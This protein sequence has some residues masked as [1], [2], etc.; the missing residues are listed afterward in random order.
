MQR[1]PHRLP[2]EAFSALA[3]GGGGAAAVRHLRA[4]ERSRHL[5]LILGVV[6]TARQAGHPHAGVAAGAYDALAAL[7]RR[8]P[9]AVDRL[10]RH[11]A[12]GAWA[13]HTVSALL[14][15]QD[16][17]H[18]PAG[19]GAVAAAAAVVAGVPYEGDVPV[20]DGRVVLPSLGALAV[21]APDGLV[22]LRTDGHGRVA[23]A[24]REAAA[25]EGL[26][27]AGW[28]GLHRLTAE[29]GGQRLSV[30]LDDLDPYR[31]PAR[32]ATP[33]RMADGERRALA[34]HLRDA[35]RVLVTGHWTI[36]Q[37]A[38]AVVAVLTPILGPEHGQ[39]SAS[40]ADLFGTVALSRPPD[41]LWLAGT[42][43]HEIQHAKLSALLSVTELVLPDDGRRFYAPWRED[44]RPAHGLLQGAYA[45]LG[46]TGFWRRQR[47]LLP[48]GD[49]RFRAE[50]EFARWRESAHHVTGT[51]AA[52]GRLTQAGETFVAAMR[53]TLEPWLKEPASRAA[54][55]AA[56]HQ[57]E[58]H[59]RRWTKA[60]GHPA[61]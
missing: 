31:W 60:H 37:E 48:P 29:A 52:S 39:N 43:A 27:S 61:A 9:T 18:D 14:G 33:V 15:R 25:G 40:S 6:D 22:R 36:A 11:P 57:S 54:T 26:E 42:L 20:T 59:R 17:A 4:A 35:W 45:Y 30:L 47:S 51:L 2:G 50:V 32:T 28:Q 55:A 21:P 1:N 13:G 16:G 3:R 5:L 56:R 46:V 23:A 10:I 19:L 44:P 38:A 7:E 41:G 49:D 12:V 24:G 53:G 58:L 8:A 34:G